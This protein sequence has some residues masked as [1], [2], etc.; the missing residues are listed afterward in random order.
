M[1]RPTVPRVHSVDVLRGV[2]M[3]LMALDHVRDYFG[4]AAASPTNLATATLPLFYTRWVTHICAPTFFLL[5]GTSA[6]LSARRRGTTGLARHL[7]TRGL[8]LIVLDLVILRCLG[9]QF[10]VDFRVTLLLVLWA[11]GWSMITLAAFVRR[12]ALAGIFGVVVIAGHNL[13]DR[14][15]P[16]SL[17]AAAP[18]WL[19]L[20][21]PGLL[22]GPP[23]FVL[24][25]YPLV[26]WVGVTAAGYALGQIFDWDAARRRAFLLRSGIGLTIAFLALRASN[27]YGDPAPWSAQRSAAYTV[28]SFLN[29]TKYPPSLLFLLMTIGVALLVLRA[30]DARVPRWLRP[31][32]VVGRVPMFYFAMHVV[33]IHLLV[34]LALA[35]RYGAV[36]WAFESPT[37][38][39][40][41]FTQPPGWPIALP[42]VYAVWALVVVALW[43]LC[44]WYAALRERRR[45]WW[46]GYV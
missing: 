13:L 7:V 26:P 4:D 32:E 33:L 23:H 19:V 43:P 14:V 8:W 5:T 16:A 28:A 21:R 9:W 25:A 45:G 10:N 2:V 36:H 39:R 34:V 44:R 41:P 31:A 18:L 11:L 37:P 12:P 38:D 29:V 6:Y 30:V 1:K 22:A 27:V 40:F 3:V 17:G 35:V 20:H 15:D 42:G 24:V 46:T